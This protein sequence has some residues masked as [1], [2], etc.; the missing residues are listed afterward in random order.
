MKI[1]KSIFLTSIVSLFSC[2]PNS[3]ESQQ[4]EAIDSIIYKSVKTNHPG[5]GV[6]IVKNGEVIYEKYRGFSNL[7]HQIPFSNKQD[8]T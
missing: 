2:N 6:G 7:Q 3:N 5:L 4:L 1:L 8:Q